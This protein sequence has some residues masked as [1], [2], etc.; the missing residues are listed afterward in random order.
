MAYVPGGEFQ[1][2]SDEGD[3]LSRPAHKV[4]VAPFFI[5]V[6]EVTN[7]AYLEFVK[8]TSHTPPARWKG[9]TTFPEGEGKFPVTGVNWYDALEYAAWVGKRLPTEAEWEFAAGGNDD[10]MYP[11]GNAWDASLANADNISKGVRKTGEGGRSPFG[12][13]DMSGNAW[14]WTSSDAKSY[15]GGKEFPWSRLKLKIIRGGN[16][17]SGSHTATTVFSR[18]L[19]CCGEREYDGTGFRCVKDV[20]KD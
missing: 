15:P 8:A 18:L 20:P 5:D 1:M 11:W 9:G 16:W 7:E 6:N 17:Q 4:A 13:F 10:R 12:L 19:R 3:P 14:E 2:G